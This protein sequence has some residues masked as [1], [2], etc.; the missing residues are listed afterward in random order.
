MGFVQENLR[1]MDS[2]HKNLDQVL[3]PMGVI[4]KK[5]KPKE[6][7]RQVLGGRALIAQAGPDISC[8]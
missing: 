2:F 5:E 7:E 3:G 6:R 8:F 4:F 1:V